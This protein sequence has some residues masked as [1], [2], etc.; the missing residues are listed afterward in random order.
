ME[1]KL[2][3]VTEAARARGVSST[4]I[5]SAITQGRLPARR[6]LN[7]WAINEKD[8]TRYQPT[9]RGNRL[10]PKGRGGRPK[11]TPLSAEH[12]ERIAASQ[13]ARWQLKKQLA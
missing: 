4:A 3:T 1:E 8:L 12:K 6:M 11:G 7:R 13:A 5:Y 2:L 10:G 9:Q